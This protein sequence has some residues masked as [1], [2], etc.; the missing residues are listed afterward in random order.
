LGVAQ[1]RSKL[2]EISH[3]VTLMSVGCKIKIEYHSGRP[4]KL[5]PD[6]RRQIEMIIKSNHFSTVSEMRALLK[7]ITQKL[8]VSERTI[9]C[10]LSNLGFT[11][12]LLRRVPLLGILGT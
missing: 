10:E 9:R 2:R 4:R 7:E 3:S 5:T 12:V 8:D 1:T 11:A 6:K